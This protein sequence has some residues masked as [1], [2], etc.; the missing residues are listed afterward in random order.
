MKSS[1]YELGIHYMPSPVHVDALKNSME[2]LQRQLCLIHGGLKFV[3]RYHA[4]LCLVDLIEHLSELQNLGSARLGGAGR[5]ERSDRRFLLCRCSHLSIF[6]FAYLVCDDIQYNFREGGSV[7]V[8]D[9]ISFDC[10]RR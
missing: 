7:L 8:I 2:F 9:Q 5:C 1:C 6:H 3:I 10:I 4:I